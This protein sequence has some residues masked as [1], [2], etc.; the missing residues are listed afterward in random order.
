MSV[1]AN[2]PEG[3]TDFKTKKAEGIPRAALPILKGWYFFSHPDYT[4]GG[5]ISLPHE[6]I[7]LSQTITAGMELH[8]APKKSD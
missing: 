4:V 6:G 1:Y 2:P 3:R 5:R 7:A 8:H